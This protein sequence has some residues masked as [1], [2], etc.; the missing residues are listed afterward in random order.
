MPLGRAQMCPGD[1]FGDGIILDLS[2]PTNLDKW[3]N[4]SGPGS[5]SDI[6]SNFDS[7]YT[8]QLAAWS[9][10]LGDDQRQSRDL[11]DFSAANLFDSC[12]SSHS[13][14]DFGS[15]ITLCPIPKLAMEGQDEQ[16][17]E[18]SISYTKKD[19]SPIVCLSNLMID[20]YEAAKSRT[21][22]PWAYPNHST[23]LDSYPVGMVLQLAQG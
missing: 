14:D 2:Q 3:V 10:L 8:P 12:H 1:E 7:D 5:G 18:S 23:G 13:T 17:T 15:D 11:F 20:I 22:S 4:I 19:E 9:N 16:E 6:R 21:D